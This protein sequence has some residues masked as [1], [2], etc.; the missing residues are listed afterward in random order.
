M[1]IIKN[2]FDTGK[3]IHNENILQVEGHDGGV[4]L[5]HF[6]DKDINKLVDSL[7]EFVLNRRTQ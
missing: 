5:D 4:N 1:V 2:R 7:V 3:I 6:S